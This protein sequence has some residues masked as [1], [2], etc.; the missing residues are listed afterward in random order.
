VGTFHPH[1]HELHGITCVVDRGA[2]G[3]VVGRVDTVTA[4]GVVLLDADACPEAPGSPA[5]DE[6]LSNAARWGVWKR[7]DRV[8]VPAGEVLSVRRLGDLREP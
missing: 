4:D 6:W 3:L 8:V 7:F 1:A 5:R 2:G